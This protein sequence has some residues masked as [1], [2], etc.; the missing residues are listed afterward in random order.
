MEVTRLDVKNFRNV[1]AAHLTF[2]PGVNLLFGENAQ[3]KTNIIESIFLFSRGKSFRKSKEADLFRFGTKGF[4][5]SME[6]L[7]R[8]GKNTLTYS[9]FDGERKRM[10]NGHKITRAADM[11][12]SFR[13]VLFTPDHLTLVKGGPEERRAFLDVGISQLTPT[14][15]ENYSYYQKILADR[16][17][18][19]KMCGAGAPVDARQIAAS[20]EIL[21]HY[22]AA[23]YTERKRYIEK[24]MQTLPAQMEKMSMG[25]DEISLSYL[26]GVRE[27]A[28]TAE[29]AEEEYV[30]IFS[31]NLPRECAAG[32]TLYGI[33]RDD[34]DILIN[35]KSARSFA[36][37]GQQRSAVLTL[38]V[39]EGEVCREVTGEYPVFL[40]D[41]VLSELDAERREYVLTGEGKRQI[42]ITSCESSLPNLK[43]D[44][45]IRVE[46]GVFSEVE[47]V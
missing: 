19:L 45:L 47:S 30:R 17:C 21:A 46:R 2:S 39:A 42:V 34:F 23:I 6:Y 33:T 43:P 14:Y 18:L 1:E 24:I 41:D 3:G 10:K 36:S 20:S 4:Y 9:V 32:T 15:I 5:L 12:G 35:G 22:A 7:D 31:E 26:S 13:S 27:G 40:F 38:K 37:Q 25:R 8:V 44:N 16:N 28:D 29:R 11:I